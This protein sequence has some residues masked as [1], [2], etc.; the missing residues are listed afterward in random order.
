VGRDGNGL[1]YPGRSVVHDPMGERVAD[2][3]GAEGCRVTELDLDQVARVRSEFP[4]Q[5]DADR[6]TLLDA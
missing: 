6:F 5:A 3:G 2:L 1:Q 4:F